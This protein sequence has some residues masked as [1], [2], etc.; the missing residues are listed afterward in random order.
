MKTV[1]LI[2][3][4]GVQAICMARSLRKLGH[5][6]VGFCNHKMTSGYTTRWLSE[7]YVSPDITLHHNEFEEFLFCFDRITINYLKLLWICRRYAIL[8]DNRLYNIPIILFGPFFSL[9]MPF[10]SIY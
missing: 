6:V 10:F 8:L 4:E 7:K 2:N 1:L 9:S 3:A 5:N